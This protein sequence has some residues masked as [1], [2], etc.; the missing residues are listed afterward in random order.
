[1]STRSGSWI[2]VFC[3]SLVAGFAQ[4]T[5]PSGQP[6][7]P[8]P[9][10]TGGN[11]Q[12]TLDVVVT[13]KS[14]SALPGLKQRDFAILDDKRPQKIES[15]RAVEGGAASTDPP[16]EVILL[17]DEVNT[18]FARVA[19]ERTEIEKFLRRNGGALAHPVSMAFFSDSGVAIGNAP[20]QDG[21]AVVAD[22]DQNRP[23]LRVLGK[24]LGSSAAVAHTESSLHALGTLVDYE[25]ARPGRKLVVWISPGW[26]FDALT[27][28]WS[29]KGR[30][31]LFD[32]R[33]A[34]S[35]GL[36]RARITLYNVDPFGMSDAN[37][38]QTT[39][40]TLFSKPLRTAGPVNLGHLALQVFALNSGGRVLNSFND[41]AGEIAACVADANAF[42]VLSF[43]APPGTGTNE[44]HAVDIKIG[45]P[46]LVARTQSGYYAQQ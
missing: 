35:E 43:D 29:S 5:E 4:Q 7:P 14:G 33:V 27:P 25:A 15:F 19:I 39:D 23:G 8:A 40:F 37:S 46:G 1:M 20:S 10:R 12:L 38:P 36:R 9:V 18:P 6:A 24:S 13:D 17:V 11:R 16:V 41:V 22:L 31:Q 34:L 30:Q 44:Y 45:K 3:F 32:A 42:Y 28:E 26:P 2:C 21:N